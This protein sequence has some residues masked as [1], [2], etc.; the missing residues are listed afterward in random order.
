MK[1]IAYEGFAPPQ[2]QR[3]SGCLRP[4]STALHS[5]RKQVPHGPPGDGNMYSVCRTKGDEQAESVQIEIGS[6]SFNGVEI[7]TAN[8]GCQ[9]HLHLVHRKT[10]PKAS[11]CTGAEGEGQANITG[12]LVSC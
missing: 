8:E 5:R 1:A 4:L 7:E 10:L 2:R 12:G 9:H 6:E 3:M 11:P